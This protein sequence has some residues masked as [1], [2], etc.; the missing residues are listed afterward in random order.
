MTTAANLL[1]SEFP[2]RRL[3]DAA[4]IRNAVTGTTPFYARKA[5]Q[6]AGVAVLFHELDVG[7]VGGAFKVVVRVTA[8]QLGAQDGGAVGVGVARLGGADGDVEDAVEGGV[9]DGDLWLERGVDLEQEALR[10]EADRAS[11]RRGRGARRA[12]EPD[13]ASAGF[14]LEVARDET[15]WRRRVQEAEHDVGEFVRGGSR[16][17]LPRSIW[18]SMV[19]CGGRVWRKCRR[20]DDGGTTA[21][22]RR[23]QTTCGFGAEP[24]R[25]VRG[26]EADACKIV[27]GALW[28][29]V[30]DQVLLVYS[31]YTTR[32]GSRKNVW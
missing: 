32:V 29:S 17:D 19:A 8:G 18:M 13:G 21:G 28:A 26:L 23:R 24:L 14:A 16:H 15:G 27:T 31:N 7:Q 1:V 4:A 20:R 11:G 25:A 5:T 2:V 22:G 12:V 6:D 10:L 30:R 9:V 3:A